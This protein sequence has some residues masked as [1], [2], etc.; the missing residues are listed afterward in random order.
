LGAAFRSGYG[1]S[2]PTLWGRADLLAELYRLL[3]AARRCV[4]HDPR[5]DVAVSEQ[6]ELAAE[7]LGRGWG[8]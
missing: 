4:V 7:A 6:V 8:R 3:F 5:W 2:D 1:A